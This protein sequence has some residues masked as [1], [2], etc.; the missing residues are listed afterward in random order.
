MDD[1]LPVNDAHQMEKSLINQNAA[2]TCERM[3]DSERC[4]TERHQLDV[5]SFSLS[6]FTEGG[7]QPRMGQGCSTQRVTGSPERLQEQIRASG[8]PQR[9]SR[10]SGFIGQ[11]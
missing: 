7:L 6:V 5:F 2:L 8:A 3:I 11:L 9:K 10:A 4:L 1:L